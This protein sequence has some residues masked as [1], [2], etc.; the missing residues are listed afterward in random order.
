MIS[1]FEFQ[2]TLCQQVASQFP[3]V[4]P[5]AVPFFNQYRSRW[6]Q[7]GDAGQPNHARFV[8]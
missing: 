3:I 4:N 1:A 7:F 6:V 2:P 5:V 8:L